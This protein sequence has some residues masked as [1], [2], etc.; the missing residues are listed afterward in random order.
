MTNHVILKKYWTLSN[1]FDFLNFFVKQIARLQFWYR[2]FV[3]K[4][5]KE[6]QNSVLIANSEKI[7]L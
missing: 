2:W 7:T 6:S 1:N 5:F 3:K 4:N